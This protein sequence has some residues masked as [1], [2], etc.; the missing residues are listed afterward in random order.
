MPTT[1]KRAN[2]K[3][4]L[5]ARFADLV[6]RMPAQAIMDDADYECAVEM[7]DRLMAS[8]KL[9]EGQ[10]LY[11]ETQVQLVQAYE[12][13]HHAIDTSD[14]GALDSLKHLLD[15]NEMNASDLAR[16][17]GVHASLG[18]KILKGDRALTL[19]HVKTLAAQFRVSPEVFI[20]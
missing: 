4:K 3:I 2:N 16:L 13:A 7:I 12:A 11:L 15:E 5:P 14:L 18:S 10:A 6:K 8:G 19:E 9:T 20:D 17:L 1:T